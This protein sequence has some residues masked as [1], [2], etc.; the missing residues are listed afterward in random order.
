M[1]ARKVDRNFIRAMLAGHNS[2]LHSQSRRYTD[3]LRHHHHKNR[4][5]N[6]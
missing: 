3:V 2:L 5:F 1:W 4:L 6:E